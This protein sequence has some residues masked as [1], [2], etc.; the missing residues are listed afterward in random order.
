MGSQPHK[1]TANVPTT[2]CLHNLRQLILRTHLRI[3]L[4]LPWIPL[5]QP[6][7]APCFSDIAGNLLP[8]GLCTC[9]CCYLEGSFP[10]SSWLPP[11]LPLVFQSDVTFSARA[12]LA[13]LSKLKLLPPQ[14]C[15][16]PSISPLS[17]DHYIRG[18]SKAALL[19]FGQGHPVQR[20]MLSSIP[21]FLRQ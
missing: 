7:W 20:R 1:A 3:L 19:T 18:F 16:P 9:C 6:H 11:S 21:K 10:V 14:T 5:L 4:R 13:T 15:L 17:L 12:S 8:Q 2:A